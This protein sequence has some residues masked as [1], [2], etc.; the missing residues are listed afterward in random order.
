MQVK[1]IRA[2]ALA[3]RWGCSLV[4]IW[5][6]RQRGDL[7]APTRISAGVVGWARM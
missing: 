4:T 1:F 6:M 7:P 3:E 2:R 5:R